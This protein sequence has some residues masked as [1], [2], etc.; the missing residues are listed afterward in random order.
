VNLLLYITTAATTD[1]N[2]SSVTEAR[3]II[4]QGYSCRIRAAAAMHRLRLSM[5]ARG[6]TQQRVPTMTSLYA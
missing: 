5:Q 6:Y 1:T 4:V 2:D 3:C